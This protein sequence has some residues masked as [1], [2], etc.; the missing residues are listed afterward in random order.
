MSVKGFIHKKAREAVIKELIIRLEHEIEQ[1]GEP[2]NLYFDI[3][4]SGLVVNIKIAKKMMLEYAKKRLENELG[5]L[6]RK[7][8][9]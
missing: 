2:Q 7:G 5:S 4:N 9:K 1:T 8:G 3:L 6:K